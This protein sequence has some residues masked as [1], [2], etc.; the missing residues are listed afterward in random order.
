MGQQISR[1]SSVEARDLP[2]N[3]THIT[4]LPKTSLSRSTAV[5]SS[6]KWRKLTGLLR[7]RRGSSFHAEPARMVSTSL[8]SPAQSSV[9]AL[10]NA[11]SNQVSDVESV[12]PAPTEPAHND[13]LD[14]QFRTLSSLLENVTMSTLRRLINVGDSYYG[15]RMYPEQNIEGS[16]DTDF[17]SF[18]QGLNS[19]DLLQQSLGTQLDMGRTLSFFRAFRFDDSSQLGYNSTLHEFERLVPVLIVGVVGL[20]DPDSQSDQHRSWVIIV[21]AHHYSVSDPVL[22]SMAVFIGLLASYVASTSNITLEGHSDYSDTR[23]STFRDSLYRI[24]RG[25]KLSQTVLDEHTESVFELQNT[26]DRC[27]ICLVDYE[28]GD[29][30]RRLDCCHEFHKDCVDQWLL[31]DNTCPIC[32]S[33]AISTEMDF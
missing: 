1:T 6:G 16:T 17:A 26:N 10:R 12:A 7:R 14:S 5:S 15:E 8:L 27:P 32:R 21:M 2:P 33:R 31:N 22:G 19:G 20:T 13:L 25:R 28:S 24:F 11:S 4:S 23:V 29:Q 3:T 18:V 30:G 9:D